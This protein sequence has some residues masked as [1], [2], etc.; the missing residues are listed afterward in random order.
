M[1]QP[2]L[3]SHLADPSSTTSFGRL[4]GYISLQ[5]RYSHKSV[6]GQGISVFRL[7]RL[8]QAIRALVS[9]VSSLSFLHSFIHPLSHSS[10]PYLTF[11]ALLPSY[12]HAHTHSPSSTPIYQ[13]TRSGR[14]ASRPSSSSQYCTSSIH[15]HESAAE[16]HLTRYW[17][18][19]RYPQLDSI[20]SSMKALFK[21]NSPPPAPIQ[22]A[23]PFPY[24]YASK[25]GILSSMTHFRPRGFS[26]SKEALSTPPKTISAPILQVKPSFPSSPEAYTTARRRLQ[27][28][29]I[30]FE[31]VL[32]LS[33][34]PSVPALPC[35]HPILDIP[36][37]LPSVPR[38]HQAT[39][40]TMKLSP[41]RTDQDFI[42][43]DDHLS[44]IP[45]SPSTPG[46]HGSSP[47]QPIY[48]YR[49]VS[50]FVLT[51]IHACHS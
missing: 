13:P 46:T 30:T 5:A 40:L 29:G 7:C 35:S 48:R 6:S 14:L 2:Q 8:Q 25:E 44:G 49:R 50:C 27:S 37:T 17:V 16:Q 39:A 33:S 24:L 45:P 42:I 32:P 4:Q 38:N 1:Q 21:R 9:E 51:V 12:H 28:G 20:S 19:H 31:E 34:V 11:P 36:A 47:R 22:P 10:P 3:A 15:I 18:R 26:F 43:P 41:I 23:M